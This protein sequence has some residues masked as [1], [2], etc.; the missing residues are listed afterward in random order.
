LPRRINR[1]ADRTSPQPSSGKDA[2]VRSEVAQETSAPVQS[3]PGN[4]VDSGSM[5]RVHFAH[6]VDPESLENLINR[7]RAR[8]ILHSAAQWRC[9]RM[10]PCAQN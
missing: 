6:F 7:R 2:P 3:F 10:N 4:R 1:K 8:C 5:S 9:I